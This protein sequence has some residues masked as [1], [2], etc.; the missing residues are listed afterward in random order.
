M[1]R[2]VRDA[3]SGN[4]F[5]DELAEAYDEL[6]EEF[7]LAQLVASQQARW[8][9]GDPGAPEDLCRYCGRPWRAWPG[10]RLDGHA[11]CIV[12]ED[13][14]RSVGDF[15]R[16][17]RV[18]YAAVARALGVTPGVVRSWAYSAGVAGP[19]CHSLR[20]RAVLG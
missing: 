20:R 9:L 19:L 15:L 5:S 10:S 2:H 3:G 16:S 14:K 8:A 1:T 18:S 13:F 11:A 4:A 6:R 7:H 17:P 12:G